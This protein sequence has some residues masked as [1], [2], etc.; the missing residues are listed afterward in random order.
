MTFPRLSDGFDSRYPLSN[1]LY[2]INMINKN[3]SFGDAFGAGWAKLKE[4]WLFFV[5]SYTTI[6]VVSGLFGGLAEGPYKD[7]EPTAGLLSLIGYLIRVWL[8]F[9]LLIA[10][11]RL[12]D[13]VKPEWRD[14]FVWREET[15]SY[16]G[17]SILY[18]LMVLVGCLF[19]VIPGL[20]F[21]VKHGFYGY[22]IADKKLGAFDALKMSGQLTD[23][24]KWSVV[25]FGLASI[26]VV[27]LGALAFGVGLFVAIPV[28]AVAF[29]F[30]YR[31]LYDQT[32]DLATATPGTVVATT[33]TVETPTAVTPV[34]PIAETVPE[35][36]VTSAPEKSEASKTDTTPTP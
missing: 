13:G 18:G 8:N 28:V 4:H 12:F 27:L 31:S 24:V 7:I 16:I 11:I 25:G 35:V 1:F 17:A 21:A 19:F 32:F 34:V 23:G 33:P 6:F 9:N 29:A 20:Y 14:L 3:F 10:V 36:M 5:L 2:Q 26:G 22:L 30:V 15:I